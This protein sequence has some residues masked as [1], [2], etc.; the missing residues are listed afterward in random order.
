M[1]T[2]SLS[3]HDCQA[4]IESTGRRNRIHMSKETADLLMAAGK[5]H[6]AKPREDVI[7]AKGKGELKTYWLDIKD[8]GSV[9]VSTADNSGSDTVP[10]VNTTDSKTTR[11]IDWQVDVLSRFLKQIVARR[12]VGKQSRSTLSMDLKPDNNNNLEWNPQPGKICLDEVQEII[13]LPEFDADAARNQDDP[14]MIELDDAVILQLRAFISAIANLYRN[15]SFHSFEHACHVTMSVTKLLSRIVMPSDLEYVQNNKKAEQQGTPHDEQPDEH[16]TTIE[17]TLHDHTY[18][19]TSDPLT[20][21]SLVFAALIHDVDHTGVP[22]TVLIEE[23]TNLASAYR[24]KSVAEQ[25]SIDLSWKLLQSDQY[26]DL[27][28]CIYSTKDEFARFRQLVVQVRRPTNLVCGF[29]LLFH[30]FSHT[31]VF[32]LFPL[33]YCCITGCFGYGYCR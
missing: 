15:N 30:R 1:L 26:K 23:N 9:P 21:F 10:A 27:R 11:L 6:W 19:I 22:N 13:W 29:F 2:N 8:D 4:R 16:N 5:G 18:G 12:N 31:Q 32:I 20:Q 28:A 14:L 33:F 7:T 3:I 24:G 25:N 17:S